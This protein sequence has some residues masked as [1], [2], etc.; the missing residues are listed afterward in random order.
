M[1]DATLQTDRIDLSESGINRITSRG[2][3]L[4]ILFRTWMSEGLNMQKPL[5]VFKLY[6]NP[7]F[8]KVCVRY[9]DSTAVVSHDYSAE[10]T[11]LIKIVEC[12]N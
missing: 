7:C 9:S 6:F 11:L 3:V 2:L 5:S 12:P 4:Y 1:T 10:K 8:H